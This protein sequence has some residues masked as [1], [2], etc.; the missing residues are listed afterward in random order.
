MSRSLP[1]TRAPSWP[2]RPWLEALACLALATGAGLLLAQA[3][4]KPAP[5]DLR[6]LAVY[7][8]LSGGTTM[9]VGWLVLRLAGRAVRLRIRT[10]VFLAGLVGSG[11]ALA[12]VF[13]TAR[14]MFLSDVHD[15]RLLVALL[16]F[17]G[18]L[19]LF[20]GL[21]VA[22]TTTERIELVA[23]GIRSLA[24]GGYGMRVDVGGGDEVAELAAR[25]NELAARLRQAQE[26]RAA[27]DRERRELTAG[28]SHDLRTPLAS[29]R[30]MV[31]ALD[32]RVVDDP[33]EV[34]RYY[35]TMRREIE[36]LMRMIE[37]L[38]ELARMD[39]GAL[40]LSRSPV[41]LQEIASEV[42]DAMQAQADRHGVELSLRVEG[43]IPT[44]LL[45]GGRMERAV[46]NLV[47][48]ALEHT[49]SG[50]RIDVCVAREDGVAALRVS[51]TG[52]G[53]DAAELPHVWDRFYRAE[54]SRARGPRAADGAGLGLAIVRG[55]VEAHGGNVS[56]QSVSEHGAAFTLR[57]PFSDP[58]DP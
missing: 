25:I 29:L 31:D 44:L 54:P 52:E 35:A 5:R 36:R 14:L 53:I 42:V 58:S 37:D 7:L 20:F 13:I 30:A 3:L 32:D 51:D 33:E 12:N 22:N 55:I 47:R 15:L 34:A 28:I 21:W 50:G 9:A 1:I 41:A 49:P 8:V 16:V 11:V 38:F 40:R 17:S 39:A 43:N 18:V 27:L 6:A 2:F 26:E 46:A 24:A 4:L 10:K 19:T 45:D 56:V 48:N 23:A 57:L